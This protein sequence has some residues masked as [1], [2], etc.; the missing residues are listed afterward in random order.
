MTL[1]GGNHPSPSLLL[2]LLFFLFP[3]SLS[4]CQ[5]GCASSW[6]GEHGVGPEGV[7]P[8]GAAPLGAIDCPDGLGRCSG[9]VVEVSRL[10]S[11]PQPCKG[12]PESCACP[13][14]RLGDCEEGCVVDDV[15]VVIER[16]VA[17]RQLCAPHGDA[18]AVAR[19]LPEQ[20][21]AG[22]DEAEL[23]RCVGGSIIACK[24]HAVVASCARGCV[25]DGASLDDDTPVRREAAF[26]ILCS[27]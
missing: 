19:V 27:R 13:W 10:T 5:R 8:P 20:S 7:S 21:P 22:C 3:F 25:R 17:L 2:S 11:I 12:S 14:D 16:D 15:D 4:A 9:G 23:Y 26:A 24:E 18:G 6:L 1:E